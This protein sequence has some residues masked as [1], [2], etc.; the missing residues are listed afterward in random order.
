[1]PPAALAILQKTRVYMNRLMVG[2]TRARSPGHVPWPMFFM[3]AHPARYKPLCSLSDASPNSPE[4][5]NGTG[6]AERTPPRG[7]CR[8]PKPRQRCIV[9][10]T[11]PHKAP[12]G[13]PWERRNAI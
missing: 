7:G 6:A 13:R 12:A 2:E 8:R 9:A 10:K 4:G 5:P 1:M 3:R 11:C